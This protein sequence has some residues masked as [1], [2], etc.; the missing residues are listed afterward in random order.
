MELEQSEYRSMEFE[1]NSIFSTNE[2]W[3]L[4]N[5]N[6]KILKEILFASNK[7]K[8]KIKGFNVYYTHVEAEVKKKP[9]L[10]VYVKVGNFIEGNPIKRNEFFSNKSPEREFFNYLKLKKIKKNY[11]K[12]QRDSILFAEPLFCYHDFSNQ[13]SYIVTIAAKNTIT[14]EK[15]LDMEKLNP[16]IK[17]GAIETAR[18]ALELF[19][20]KGIIYRDVNPGNILISRTTKGK[21][22]LID[23]EY[24]LF[25]EDEFLQKI[26]KLTDKSF[27]EIAREEIQ[28]LKAYT[29]YDELLWNYQIKNSTITP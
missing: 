19:H 22:T 23:P 7:N 1:G 24:V 13:K 6:P 21:C 4:F 20:K 18:K 2:F 3:N 8:I 29:H 26:I 12:N 9:T 10:E 16:E 27:E 5:K 28:I 25:H 15:L 11:S 14:L 17:I